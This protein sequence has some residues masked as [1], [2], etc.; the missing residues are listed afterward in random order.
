MA[1]L[2]GAISIADLVDGL[3]GAS[4]VG[5]NEVHTFIATPEGMIDDSE[6]TSFANSYTVFVGTDQRS[7]ETGQGDPSAGYTISNTVVT[8]GAEL[9]VTIS[10]A[11]VI[12]VTDA[13]S[14]SG[15]ANADVLSSVTITVTLRVFIQS[16]S[17]AQY[18]K[19]IVLTKAKGGNARVVRAVANKQTFEFARGASS[20][21]DVT[22]N[23][24]LTIIGNSYGFVAAD[25][26]ALWTHRLDDGT[27]VAFPITPSLVNVYDNDVFALST[28]YESGV[29][30]KFEGEIY[31]TQQAILVSN[32]DEPD[33]NSGK[34][35]IESATLGT[36]ETTTVDGVET[37][38]TLT[39]TP[40]Q[41]A[42]TL[43]TGTR[44]SYNIT[45][46]FNTRNF[47]DEIAVIK[48][49]DALGA[50]IVSV[51]SSGSTVFKNASGTTDLTAALEL[52]GTARPFSDITIYQWMK[53]NI[54]LV[55][56]SASE[57]D[58]T[59]AYSIDT[60]VQFETRLYTANKAIIAD[61]GTPDVN[62]ADWDAGNFA[63]QV[64]QPSG[65]LP[66]ESNVDGIAQDPQLRVGAADV[67]DNGADIF[68]VDV[69]FTEI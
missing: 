12:T 54:N 37:A 17:I 66:F 41:Y 51:T 48:I 60:V 62:T 61:Q 64:T 19:T 30:L 53:E 29:R 15:F 1:T 4:I 69:T 27:D 68:T 28:A 38:S 58:I 2:T 16:G 36:I 43:L 23:N 67:T 6:L 13:G 9:T 34:F 47:E 40:R 52:S 39:V 22:F 32:T 59:L 10:N 20:A 11:G 24:S 49:E 65:F 26:G 3:A 14:N 33:G 18:T 21:K 56:S 35:A 5:S 42:L 63:L 44:V 25:A 46:V 45:R 8:S 55:V 50:Y 57:Y 31:V 7:F